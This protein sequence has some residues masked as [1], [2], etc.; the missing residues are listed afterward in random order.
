MKIFFFIRNTCK[1]NYYF[2]SPLRFTDKPICLT[3]QKRIYGVARHEEARV[4]CRVEAYPLPDKFHWA[5]NN[6]E[7]M[8][9]VPEARYEDS[10]D[11]AQSVLTYKPASELDYGTVSCWASNAAGK[12][13]TPCLFHVI[14][15]GNKFSFFRNKI[16]RKTFV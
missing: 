1:K 5:F 15:A 6:T 8:T 10:K 7:E 14:A 11:H 13:T 2:F 9:N 4:A 3:D 16:I 12:Q